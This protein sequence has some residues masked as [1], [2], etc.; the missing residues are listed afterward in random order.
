MLPVENDIAWW[1]G[2]KPHEKVDRALSELSNSM[3]ALRASDEHHL[4]LYSD[5]EWQS[6]YQNRTRAYRRNPNRGKLSLNVVRNM[7]NSATSMI[8]RSKPYVSFMTDGGD[9]NLHLAAR[10]RER[11]VQAHL[12]RERAHIL[13][14]KVVKNACIFGLGAVQVMRDAGKIRLELVAPGELF[15]DEQEANRGSVRSIYRVRLIDREV[16]KALYPKKASEIDKSSA[17]SKYWGDASSSQVVLIDAWHMPSTEGGEDGRHVTCTNTVTLAE[18][19]YK[20]DE[21]PFAIFRW[22]EE[23]FGWYGTGIPAELSGIQYEINTLLRLIQQNMWSG[24]NLKVFVEKGS[25]VSPAHIS[26]DLRGAIIEYTGTP[27]QMHANDV[28]SPQILQHLQYLV[29]NA[30]NVT[31]ISQLSAQSQTPFA[32]MSGRARLVHQNSES[33]RF[34]TQTERYEDFFNQLARRIIEAATDLDEAGYGDEVVIFK[35]RSHLE[36]VKIADVVGDPDNF[37]IQIWS[38]SQLP[39]TVA[40]RLSIVEQLLAQGMVDQRRALQLLDLPDLRGEQDIAEAPF[41]LAEEHISRIIYEGEF[42]MP[43]ASLNLE[44]ALNRVQLEI[45]RCEMRRGTPEDRLDMLRDWKEY[46]VDLLEPPE[47][48]AANDMGG[49][50]GMDPAAMGGAPPMGTEPPLPALSPLAGQAFQAAA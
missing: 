44:Y 36:Q 26:N 50:M 20:W 42:T 5:A 40:G 45:A 31:G 43:T 39:Q 10:K 47:Q 24:G 33:L 37:E 34:K 12:M 38:S 18:R 15:V 28:V 8:C 4:R 7:V 46:V 6:T 48:A 11:F 2:K 23:P 32:S 16:L 9:W 3:S 21:A 1:R 41:N 17:A 19:P 29:E 49:M 27:P 13:A 25:G 14:H 22:E 30:Y 35:D